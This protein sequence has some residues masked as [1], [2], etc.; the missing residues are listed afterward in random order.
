MEDVLEVQPLQRK[1]SMLIVTAVNVTPVGMTYA[2]GTSDYEVEV[3]IN[4]QPPI[5]RGRI[6]GHMRD[7]GAGALLRLIANEVEK[8]GRRS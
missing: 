2:D 5:W 1:M 8:N 4:S 6:E 7:K 3:A